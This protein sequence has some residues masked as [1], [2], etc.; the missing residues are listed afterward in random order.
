[1]SALRKVRDARGRG[2]WDAGTWAL[3]GKS[4]RSREGA[5]LPD[6]PAWALPRWLRW[7]GRRLIGT[8][9]GSGK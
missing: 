5:V 2:D 7:V 1:M 3:S 4:R 8:R 9:S 6:R